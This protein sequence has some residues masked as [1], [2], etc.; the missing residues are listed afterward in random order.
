MLCGQ[1]FSID[2]A[3]YM[4]IKHD[5]SVTRKINGEQVKLC[6]KKVWV[7]LVVQGQ[8]IYIFITIKCNFWTYLDEL[9]VSSP[10]CFFQEESVVIGDNISNDGLRVISFSTKNALSHLA[11][12][13][14]LHADGTFKVHNLKFQTLPPS[15]HLS[16][17]APVCQWVCLFVWLFV[18]LFPNSS[19]TANP[20]KL[21]YWEMILLGM[22]KVLG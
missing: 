21:K 7:D 19:E 14:E 18:C 1:I 4:K 15:N 13:S 12:S 16:I 2:H 20:S 5:G 10:W 22:E 17:K 6:V 11:R 9:N 3:F 8:Y